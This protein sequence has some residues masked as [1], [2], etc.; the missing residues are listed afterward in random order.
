MFLKILTNEISL[1]LFGKI[2]DKSIVESFEIMKFVN[3]P[4]SYIIYA[5]IEQ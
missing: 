2:V 5:I 1:K 3:W 4:M